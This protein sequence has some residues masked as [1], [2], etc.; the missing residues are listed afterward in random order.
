MKKASLCA[1]LLLLQLFAFIN[2]T[3]VR[4]DDPTLA[5]WE[6]AAAIQD[7]TLEAQ[8]QMLF[9][10]R[11]EDPD[12]AYLEA[13]KALD[14]A[15]AQYESDFA[16]IF[17]EIAPASNDAIQLAAADAES[18]VAS[19]D[20]VAL[21]SA[22][23]RLWTALLWGS[24]EAVR[25][26]LE[27]G[28][29]AAAQ[30][31]LRLREYR[32]ATRVSV[33]ENVSGRAFTAYEAGE[34]DLTELQTRVMN[35]LNDTY[36]FRFRAALNEAEAAAYKGMNTRAAEWAGLAQGYFTILETDY[37][38][39]Q[40]VDQTALLQASLD[41][42]TALTLSSDAE[43]VG[44]TVADVRVN[45]GDYLPVSFTA[46]ETAERA[47]MLVLF[48]KT[49]YPEYR[50]GVREGVITT[51]VEY[52]E[53]LTFTDQAQSAF[54]ELRPVIAQHDA[55][56][57]ERLNELLPEIRSVLEAV[58]PVQDVQS[59]T[60]E[61]TYLVESNLETQIQGD[62]SQAAFAKL[63]EL[64]DD[65]ER[66]ARQG[67]YADA[68]TLR[69]Q[70]YAVWDVGPEL[71]LAA[72][73][74]ELMAR[75]EGLFWQGYGDDIGL[76]QGIARRSKYED[77]A[78]ARAELDDSL[79]LAQVRLSRGSSAPMAIVFNTAVIVF[80]EGLEAVV[81]LAA[82]MASMASS[83]Q[84]GYRKPVAWGA[85]AAFAA[86]ALT[87]VIMGVALQSLRQYG[88]KLEAVVSLIAIA[89]LLLI[90][91]WFFHKAYWTDWMARFHRAKSDM[92]R[93][94][95]AR[96][97]FLGLLAI[98]FTSIYR[99]GFETVLFLQALVLDAGVL[100]VLEGVFLGLIAVSA[101]G[102]VA[103]KLQTRLPYKTMLI[104]TGVMI[105]SVLFTMVGHT[106]HVM[107]AVG[108]MP[109]TPL[110]D[111][112]VPYWA[113]L[114]LGIYPTMQTLLGQVIALTFVLGSYGL[115]E[116]L[117]TRKRSVRRSPTLKEA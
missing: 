103:F 71:R 56:A 16:P 86:S 36:F 28:D 53:A 1:C 64:L 110:N 19:A 65:L 62:D 61:A 55:L 43:A 74:P 115:A 100:V 41:S 11:A 8:T 69:I 114:W 26:S 68:E 67:R 6:S 17:A 83:K 95:N 106:I 46:E 12:A 57:A 91:N 80:R 29:T 63:D 31:W 107:Q 45:I 47:Q 70:A 52:Q 3:L 104:V 38:T 40:G 111:V 79:A 9:A 27:S 50:D 30:D 88:E 84:R 112:T 58:G 77:I 96:A 4:A 116:G 98:G 81:I 109:I 59:M 102:Y 92:V 48:L 82:L 87:F 23:G 54:E 32:Q 34:I 7:L 13:G 108:W 72:R 44:T 20:S 39:K 51:P 99:E 94:D 89:V 33:V 24:Y 10:A 97:Q 85:A 37:N 25:T 78:A 60:A 76:A 42:L 113:G 14:E 93:N 18:A 5:Q 101:V 49:I 90:T 2:P 75:I 15:L 66:A 21:G 73:E 117:R 35:D 22:R 105:L